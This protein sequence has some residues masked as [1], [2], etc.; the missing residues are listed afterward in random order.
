MKTTLAEWLSRDICDN[1]AASPRRIADG[2]TEMSIQQVAK[3]AGFLLHGFPHHNGS[4]PVSEKTAERVWRAIRELNIIPT[5][6]RERW[7]R[8]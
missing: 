3:K 2:A 7:L 4:S 6:T 8:A 5:P 1:N